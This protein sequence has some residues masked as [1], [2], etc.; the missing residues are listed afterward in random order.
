MPMY[1][2][3]HTEEWGGE[4]GGREG[5]RERETETETEYQ[6][7]KPPALP[8]STGKL[9]TLLMPG[10]RRLMQEDFKCRVTEQAHLRNSGSN[11]MHTLSYALGCQVSLV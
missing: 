10:L 7:D 1:T 4:L 2:H 9:A 3:I 8:F 11:E 5:K 6:Y